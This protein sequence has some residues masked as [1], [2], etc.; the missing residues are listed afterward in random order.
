MEDSFEMADRLDLPDEFPDDV[1][2]TQTE[3][4]HS[5]T[6]RHFNRQRYRYSNEDQMT[7]NNSTSNRISIGSE[8][9]VFKKVR[10]EVV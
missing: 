8:V 2:F 3:Q 9:Q 7:L 10:T 6:N 4:L 5:S 1:T